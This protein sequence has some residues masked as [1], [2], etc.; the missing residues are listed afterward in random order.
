MSF[1][2]ALIANLAMRGPHAE[3]GDDSQR[4][5]LTCHISRWTAACRDKARFLG[6]NGLLIAPYRRG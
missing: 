5:I 3:K 2:L 1:P 6:Q 4:E